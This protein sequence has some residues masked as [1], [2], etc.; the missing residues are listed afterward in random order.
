MVLCE[1]AWTGPVYWRGEVPELAHCGR[2]S[3][4]EGAHGSG[5]GG[6]SSIWPLAT[7]AGSA[8]EAEM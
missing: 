6:Y 4:N 1:S 5:G 3:D 7:R 2:I 8:G